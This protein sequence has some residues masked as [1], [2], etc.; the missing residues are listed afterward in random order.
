MAMKKTGPKK[1]T[2]L[3]TGEKP[4]Q[5]SGMAKKIFMKETNV[6]SQAAFRAG[7]AR[8]RFARQ[9]NAA[10]FNSKT[11]TVYSPAPMTATKKAAIKVAAA[12]KQAAKKNPV[13]L[14]QMNFDKKAKKK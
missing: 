7:T 4:K 5:I 10:V 9:T 14:K 6:P 11:P 12:K 8:D 13:A 2:K 3:P 1:T